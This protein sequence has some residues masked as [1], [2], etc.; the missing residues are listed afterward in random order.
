VKNK[1][2]DPSGGQSH[3]QP[4]ELAVEVVRLL[5]TAI[6]HSDD[7]KA[8]SVKMG[9]FMERLKEA[10]SQQGSPAARTVSTSQEDGK[11]T[12]R[13]HPLDDVSWSGDGDRKLYRW[14]A[15]WPPEGEGF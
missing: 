2:S 1:H 7:L 6:E 15:S 3:R 14:A 13:D 12:I 10:W 5:R 8:L 11:A 4:H 9:L